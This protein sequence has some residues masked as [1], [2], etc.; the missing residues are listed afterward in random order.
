MPPSDVNINLCHSINVDSFTLLRRII[1]HDYS[2]SHSFSQYKLSNWAVVLTIRFS[3]GIIHV[4]F[5]KIKRLEAR[6][7]QKAHQF[8]LE[9][10]LSYISDSTSWVPPGKKAPSYNLLIGHRT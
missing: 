8:K 7:C 5:F 9:S 4:E 2:I 6:L 10:F 1:F 3:L